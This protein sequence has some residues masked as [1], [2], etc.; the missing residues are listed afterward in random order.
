MFGRYPDMVHQDNFLRCIRARELPTAD[1]REGHLST[2]L[3][4]A[5]DVT[6]RLGGQNLAH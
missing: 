1:I 5:A 3:C 4:Q 6:G 2:L